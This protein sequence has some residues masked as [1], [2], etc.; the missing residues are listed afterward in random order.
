MLDKDRIY[1]ETANTREGLI[2]D[3]YEA[4]DLN[5]LMNT[6]KESKVGDGTPFIP[7]VSSDSAN[8]RFFAIKVRAM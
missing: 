8:S 6:V 4:N 1:I 7:K 5:S 3:F 2:Y